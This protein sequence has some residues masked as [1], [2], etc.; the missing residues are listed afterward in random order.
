MPNTLPPPLTALTTRLG[1]DVEDLDPID[2]ARATQALEDATTLALAE[3]A[4]SKAT[5]WRDDAPDAVVLVIVKAAR[6]EYENPRGL[7]QESMGEHSVGMAESSGVYLTEREIA[8]I[9]RA[10][11][12][13]RTARGFVGSVRTPSAYSDGSPAIDQPIFLTIDGQRPVGMLTLGDVWGL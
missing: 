11:T 8:Q 10:A 6:R 9:V 3:V 7:T 1:V 4:S 2:V 5:A 12:G 13:R